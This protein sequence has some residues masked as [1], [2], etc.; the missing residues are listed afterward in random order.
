M[1]V[2]EP[3]G[4]KQPADLGDLIANPFEAAEPRVVIGVHDYSDELASDVLAG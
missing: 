3:T 2:G 1:L 4:A